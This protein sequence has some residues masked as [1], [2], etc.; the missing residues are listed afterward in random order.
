MLAADCIHSRKG[1]E[2]VQIPE[3]AFHQML[4]LY[5]NAGH[6]GDCAKII[7]YTFMH[8]TYLMNQYGIGTRLTASAS[9]KGQLNTLP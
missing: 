8:I 5:A 6:F 2:G 4:R 3:D 1:A 7:V 9:R